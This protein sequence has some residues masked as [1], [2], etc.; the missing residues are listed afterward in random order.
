L[1]AQNARNPLFAVAAPP[2]P[3]CAVLHVPAA[4]R[5]RICA[6]VPAAAVVPA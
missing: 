1:K 6:N 2:L 3:V 5:F 4:P